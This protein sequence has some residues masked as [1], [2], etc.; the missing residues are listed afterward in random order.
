[1]QAFNIFNINF[2]I[3]FISTYVNLYFISTYYVPNTILK[4]GDIEMSK[5][6]KIHVPIDL[7]LGRETDKK[8]K[9]NKTNMYS[10]NKCWEDNKTR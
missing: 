8:T 2:N 3:Y 10:N 1:M 5:I 7:V 6:N 9:Q 4:S